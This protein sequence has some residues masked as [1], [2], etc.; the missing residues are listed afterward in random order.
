MVWRRMIVTPDYLIVMLIPIALLAGV[1]R[2]LVDWVPFVTLLLLWEAMRGIAPLLDMP[3]HYGGLDWDQRLF[4][5]EVPT[6][7][8]QGWIN[9]GTLGWI[10]NNAATITY[11]L[12]F[13][14]TLGIGVILWSVDRPRFLQYAATLLGMAAVAFLFFLLFPTAPPWYAA[15]HG[16]LPGMQHIFAT[17]FPSTL[18]PYYSA[19]NPNPVAAVPSL[20]AAFPFLGYLVLRDR[21]KAVSRV[22]LAWCFAVWFCVVYLG[23]HYVLDVMA[24]ILLARASWA[25]F[26]S[27][28]A[29]RVASFQHRAGPAGEVAQQPL[30]A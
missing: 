19:L 10:V 15:E 6:L 16:L 11:L 9:H 27:W 2:F 13:P 8:L 23:E 17:T 14:F 3:V 22:A 1:Q 7:I 28:I 4:G 21:L 12:H 29:P 5:G 25:I 20:H 24:G 18:S 26:T 30:V